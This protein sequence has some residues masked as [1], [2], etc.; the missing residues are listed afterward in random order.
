MQRSLVMMSIKYHYQLTILQQ[1]VVICVM[2]G[3]DSSSH[4]S[5]RFLLIRLNPRF[6]NV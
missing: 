1:M 3:A 5:L 4:L 6:Y 2:K